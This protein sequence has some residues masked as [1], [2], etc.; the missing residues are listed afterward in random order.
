[1]LLSPFRPLITVT[2][3]HPRILT[4]LGVSAPNQAG[5][6]ALPGVSWVIPDGNWSNHAGQDPDGAGLSWVAAIV[7]AVGGYYYDTSGQQ[8]RTSC[9]NPNGSAMYWKNTAILITW[10]DWGGWYDHVEPWRSDGSDCC[11]YYG[12]SFYSQQ[13]VYGFRVP[14]LVVSAYTGSGSWS[15]TFPAGYRRMGQ[16]RCSPMSMTS[17]AFLTS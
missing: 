5:Q 14:M 13:Y 4:D 17:A 10:D 7:N 3:Q 9:Q 1:M 16:A 6:C 8:H 11:G 15:A 2:F 12:D